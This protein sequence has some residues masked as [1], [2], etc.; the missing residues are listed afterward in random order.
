M[1]TKANL[2]V[3]LNNKEINQLTKQ[4]KE[5]VAFNHHEQKTFGAADLWNIQK[6]RRAVRSSRR[7]FV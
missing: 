5:T 3:S 1:K 2:L 6:M 7:L 4:V